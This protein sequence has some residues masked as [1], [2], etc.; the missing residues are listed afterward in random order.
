MVLSGCATVFALL[1]LRY[2]A[3]RPALAA[4]LPSMLVACALAAIAAA[5]GTPTHIL[6]LIGLILVMG[7]GVDYGIFVWDSAGSAEDTGATLQSLLLSALTTI[8][9]FGVMGLSEHPVLHAV[10]RTTA[11]GIALAFVLAPVSLVLVRGDAT[12]SSA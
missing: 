5:T 6:H 2:G 1:W 9:V 12:R 4:A 7:M 3:F 8:F 10:G 11:L